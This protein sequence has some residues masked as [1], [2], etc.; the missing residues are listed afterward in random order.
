MGRTWEGE[1]AD[2]GLVSMG[3][4]WLVEIVLL[5]IRKFEIPLLLADYAIIL[6]LCTSKF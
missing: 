3:W 1:S 5:G 6:S 2:N 4:C